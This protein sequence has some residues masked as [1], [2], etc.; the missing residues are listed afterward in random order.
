MAGL[1][2]AIHLFDG[3]RK[4]VDARDKPAHDE[5]ATCVAE[6]SSCEAASTS[7]RI[8]RLGLRQVRGLA[9]D[10]AKKLVAA[11][12][13]GYRTPAELMH[14]AR[15]GR[16]VMERLAAADAFRSMGLDRREALWAVAGLRDDGLPLLAPLAGA[17]PPEPAATL[18]AMPLGEH[19]AEDYLTLGL[20]LKRHPLALL[21]DELAPR[22]ILPAARLVTSRNGGRVT[23][24]GLVLVRQQ[25]GSASGVIFMTLEDET[26]VANLV[27]WP[28]VFQRFR[29]IVMGGRLVECRGRLQREGEVIHVVADHLTDLSPLL[30]RLREGEPLPVR[31]RDFR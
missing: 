15:L 17:A 20:S 27:V 26:G 30:Q 5:H 4:G 8:L 3:S 25:P 23:V 16:G 21:R 29:R 12:G 2:P 31:S 24:A 22:G 19:V 6:T 9:E 7:P 11:R 1:V 28:P 18:P 14:R 10:D 13:T